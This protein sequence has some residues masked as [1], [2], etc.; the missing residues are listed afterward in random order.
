MAHHF[1]LF[2]HR[3]LAIKKV[4]NAIVEILVFSFEISLAATAVHVVFFALVIL[5]DQEFLLGK[6][7]FAVLAL[8]FGLLAVHEVVPDVDFE[9]LELAVHALHFLEIATFD[10][11]LFQLVS[12]QLFLATKFFVW[13]VKA[14]V[15][16]VNFF[17]DF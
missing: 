12:G 6:H 14:L 4:P 8:H 9:E 5:M 13:A 11:V 1:Y 16:A 10:H 3:F 15:L 17:V 7:A 2:L